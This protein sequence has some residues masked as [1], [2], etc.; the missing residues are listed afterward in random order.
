MVVAEGSS[1]EVEVLKQL[2]QKLKIALTFEM[3]WVA[4]EMERKGLL[5]E[6]DYNT[7][8][9]S[10]SMLEKEEKSSLIVQSLILKVELD[11]DNLNVFMGILRSKPKIYKEILTKLMSKCFSNN[12][13]TYV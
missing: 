12:I 6:A 5:S 13:S 10:K 9:N 7:I 4:G 3:E 8:I 2:R 11:R 1:S